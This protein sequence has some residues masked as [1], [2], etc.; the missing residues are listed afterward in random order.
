MLFTSCTGHD[1]SICVFDNDF[2]FKYFLKTE[3]F[4]RI[5]R[6]N[7]GSQALLKN[8]FD[9]SLHKIYPNLIQQITKV[10]NKEHHLLHASC[11]FYN[12]GFDHA[13]V[14]VIDRNG[15]QLQQEN[16]KFEVHKIRESESTYL[17]SYPNVFELLDLRLWSYRNDPIIFNKQV[18]RPKSFMSITKVY[19]TATNFIG[20]DILENGK[21]M[22]LAAY[23]K[24][25]MF[26]NFFDKN[27]VPDNLLFTT[28]IFDSFKEESQLAEQLLYCKHP[29][30]KVGLMTEND[31]QEYADYAFQV[32]KQ[33]QEQVLERISYMIN[34]TGV[35]NVCIVGG[36]G[37]N[38]VTNGFLVNH[39]PGI[40]FFF[41]PIADDTGISLG[42]YYLTARSSTLDKTI[43]PLTNTFFHGMGLDDR[44]DQFKYGNTCTVEDVANL[45]KD[46]KSVAVY[47]GMAE[48]GP[49]ALGNRSILFN[50]GNPQAKSIVNKI[51]KREWYR[52]FAAMVL[53]E[54]F[55]KYFDSMGLE[56]A[57]FMTISFN[58]KVPHLIPGVTHVDN[59][60]RVQTV[61]NSIPHIYNLL[62]AIKNQT[63]NSVLLNTSLNLA[64]E[65]LVETVEE[66]VKT[67]YNSELDALWFPDVGRVIYGDKNDQK[68]KN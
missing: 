24:D 60:C 52:P 42:K 57:P 46:N 10:Y 8:L 34:K 32:Q 25:T 3:R 19:E 30:N 35:K 49:R 55:S 39:L 18:Y 11:A 37:L 40:N 54:D 63:G 1:S 9:L 2:Q 45:I 36:Y 26:P 27:G 51:K 67:Y 56:E 62:T 4:T 41:E 68:N 20:E 7:I 48:A 50:A 53:K 64:G 5:K 44:E 21:T 23:G 6:D 65:P 14:F 15:N 66:A 22:G 38:V 28:R 31:F 17:A 61:D 47:R 16:T 13:L 58:V 59:S 33:T 29:R 12:S 43:T